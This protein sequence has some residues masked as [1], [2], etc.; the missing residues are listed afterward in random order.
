M[1]YA[2]SRYADGYLQK[3]FDA[4]NG[5]YTVG[6]LRSFPTTASSFYYYVWTSRDR[7]DKIALERLGNSDLWWR[8]LDFNPEVGNPWDIPVG[9]VLRIPSV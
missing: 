1:I 6:V 4:R 2:D 7:L 8:I 5:S 9:T 3:S